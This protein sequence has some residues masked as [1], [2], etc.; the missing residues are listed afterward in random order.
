MAANLNARISRTIVA[1]TLIAALI[2][3]LGLMAYF[4]VIYEWLYPVEPEGFVGWRTAD[5]VMVLTV[6]AFGLLTAPSR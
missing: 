2:V 1:L 6:L 5:T 4:F 3:W